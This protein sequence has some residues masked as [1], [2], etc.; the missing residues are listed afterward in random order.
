M[1]LLHMCTKYTALICRAA[2]ISTTGNFNNISCLQ[3]I[4]EKSVCLS[5]HLMSLVSSTASLSTFCTFVAHWIECKCNTL[6]QY[7][8]TVPDCVQHTGRCS[9]VI[10]CEY[11]V[12]CC[13]IEV[14]VFCCACSTFTVYDCNLFHALNMPADWHG[15]TLHHERC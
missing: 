4:A 12:L 10:V 14:T 13:T 2:S 7:I 1:L 3:L 9:A 15:R 11:S 5:A 8:C 6:K